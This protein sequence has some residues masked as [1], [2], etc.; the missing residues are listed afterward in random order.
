[1][2]SLIG[3]D[4]NLRFSGGLILTHTQITGSLTGGRYKEGS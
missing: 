2:G 1:M 4:E 3:K